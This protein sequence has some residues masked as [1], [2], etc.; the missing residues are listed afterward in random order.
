MDWQTFVIGFFLAQIATISVILLRLLWDSINAK[1]RANQQLD[2]QDAYYYGVN[3]GWNAHAKYPHA[4][5]PGRPSYL[6]GNP[7]IKHTPWRPEESRSV[8]LQRKATGE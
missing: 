5:P 1:R 2:I 8:R 7:P 3:D 6:Y 4:I